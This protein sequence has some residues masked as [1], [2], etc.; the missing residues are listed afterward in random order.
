MSSAL[1]LSFLSL[2]WSLMTSG[3]CSRGRLE[4]S[5]GISLH[6]MVGILQRNR[7]LWHPHSPFVQILVHMSPASFSEIMTWG[8]T[9]GC[10]VD[11]LGQ[12]DYI[13]VYPLLE[14]LCPSGT[15]QTWGASI[16]S[17][18]LL[19]IGHDSSVGSMV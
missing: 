9:Q 4:C 3:G 7:S 14:I 17:V 8:S 5:T 15:L 19:V 11:S 6:R 16:N 10:I 1:P 12:T 2:E 13:C 18:H